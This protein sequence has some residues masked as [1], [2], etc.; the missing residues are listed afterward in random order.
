MADYRNQSV[1][2]SAEKVLEINE[3][4][5]IITIKTETSPIA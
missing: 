5:D 4:S 3:K 1:E 2:K